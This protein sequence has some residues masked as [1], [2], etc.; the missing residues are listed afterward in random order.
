MKTVLLGY[1]CDLMTGGTPSRAHKDYFEGGKIRWL[2]SGDIHQG[3]IFD[4]EGRITEIGLKNS[5]ARFLP[6]NSILIA[7][8]GQGKTRGTVAM[9]KTKATC[10]QSL[11][12]I[13]PK[14]PDELLP[15]YVFQNLKGRYQ[16]IR[17][18]TG[19]TGNERRGLNM[20]LI[21]Q[22][23]IS[24]PE[25][26]GEQKR[27]VKKLDEAFATIDKAKE[28]TE[29]NL[30]NSQELFEHE[31]KKQI[32]EV[33]KRYYLPIKSTFTIKSGDFMPK[34]SM[35]L[36]GPYNVLGGNGINGKH[37]RY[38]ISGENIVIGRVGA[39][40]GN[41]HLINESAWLTD[42]AF[43]IRSYLVDVNKKY[44]ST[45]LDYIDLG[46][47]AHQAAQP[48]ISYKTIKDLL[49]PIPPLKTQKIIN[50]KLCELLE[51]TQKLQKIYQQKLDNLEE[52]RQSILKQAFEG[53]L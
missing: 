6:V 52:L 29:R 51:K 40:C 11:V 33:P 12:S 43:V 14:N 7:L 48:V 25:S 4:C 3:E 46:K 23:K 30:K 42:N 37:N 17:R 1:V 13:F 32:N 53:K 34:R 35:I 16:E 31:L 18:M 36:S 45:I 47:T 10:N 20:K 38:N 24:Y 49:I 44:L 22:I 9:L 27:I 21:R 2:V 39:K 50:Q 15:E 41:V 8:N 28:N 5:N 26:I 19:D